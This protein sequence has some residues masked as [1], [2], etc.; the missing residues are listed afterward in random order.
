M[1]LSLCLTQVELSFYLTKVERSLYLAKVKLSLCLAQVELGFYLA[2][3][4]LSLCLAHFTYPSPEH[5]Q[6]EPVQQVVRAARTAA[7][8][9][10]VRGEAGTVQSNRQAG[11]V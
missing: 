4:E 6:A 3:V 8:G 7:E 1:E 10:A 5:C 11:S 9:T 2:H